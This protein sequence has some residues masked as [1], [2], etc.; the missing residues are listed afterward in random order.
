M[1]HLDRD[2]WVMGE[3]CQPYNLKCWETDPGSVVNT[4]VGGH[5]SAYEGYQTFHK[6]CSCIESEHLPTS[7]DC[8]SSTPSKSCGT[9]VPVAMYAVKTMAHGL[10]NKEAVLNMQRHIHE[11]GPIYVSYMV[12]QSFMSWDWTTKPI[13]TGGGPAVGGHAVMAVGWGKHDGMDYWL[14]RNSWGPEYDEAG[15]FKFRRGVNLDELESSEAAASMSREG[16]ADWSAPVCDITSSL[17]TWSYSGSKLLD[18]TLKLSVACSKDASL[19]IFF[20]NRL[21]ERDQIY[22]GVSGTY[23][24]TNVKGSTEK[25][26]E[27]NLICRKFGVADGET[28]IMITATDASKN[29]GETSHF[30]AIPPVA[31]MTSTASCR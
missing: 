16:Y 10:S 21:E 6:P 9:R 18:Y 26:V 2:L 23:K 4:A 22:D 19:E 24:N 20:S 15:Y 1:R 28:W 30:L 25:T 14:L 31:G 3:D 5:C 7:Y 8:P 12:S 17:R 29:K 13:Y 11:G 27:V